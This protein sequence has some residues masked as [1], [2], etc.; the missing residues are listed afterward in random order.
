MI[1]ERTDPFRDLRSEIWG[2]EAPPTVAMIKR[3]HRD[4]GLFNWDNRRV[5]EV[6]RKFN[7]TLRE[8]CAVVGI[9]N[10]NLIHNYSKRDQ[11]PPSVALH[12]YHLEQH[13]E[14]R[15]LGHPPQD[16]LHLLAKA[17]Q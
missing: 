8:A 1:A 4:I 10:V 6:C 3:F 14:T 11:W 13:Y 5:A 7:W 9:H 16:H 15:R 12:F 2:S 17:L